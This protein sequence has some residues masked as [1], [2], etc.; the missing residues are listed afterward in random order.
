MTVHFLEEMRSAIS[1]R[2]SALQMIHIKCQG[3]FSL[4]NNKCYLLQFVLVLSGSAVIEK[5][6]VKPLISNPAA[7][8][9]FCDN[10]VHYMVCIF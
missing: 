4:K 7:K 9:L 8:A 5:K 1:C 6:M 3:L 10:T 2:L